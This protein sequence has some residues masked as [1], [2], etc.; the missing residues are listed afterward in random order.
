MNYVETEFFLRDL[1]KL[2][3]KFPTLKDDLKSVKKAAIELYHTHEIDN[4]SVFELQGFSNKKNITFWKIKKFACRSLKGKGVNSGMRAIYA[5]HN[6]KEKIAF[7][8][9]YFKGN[10][11]NEDRE[12]I[13]KYLS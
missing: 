13:K 11:E 10:K 2:L 3:K 1:K 6:D 9:I 12:R 8:E 7:L 5:Y 4:Q